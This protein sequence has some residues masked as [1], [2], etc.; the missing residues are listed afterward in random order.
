VSTKLEKL[1]TATAASIIRSESR[2]HIISILLIAALT[3]VIGVIS[4]PHLMDDVDGTQAQIARNMI[5]SGDWVT[6]RLDG[7]IFL[8]KAPLKFWMTVLLYRL[9]GVHDWVARIPNA[10]AALFLS[11]TVYFIGR[12][13]GSA[14]IGYY[15]G[16]VTA[17]SIG[18]FLFT[19]IVIP[20]IILTLAITLALWG[21]LRAVDDECPA[22]RYWAYVFFASMG[23]AML[24][25]GLI[26]VVFP[27]AIA[28]LYLAI[29]GQLL[30]LSA[31][32]RL[33]VGTGILMF[34]A[35][36]APWHILAI[37]RN[38]PYFDF[39]IHAGDHFGYKFRGFFWFYFVNDQI[40]RFINERW[41]RDYNTVPRLW[42]WLYHLI[43]FFPWSFALISTRA[44]QFTRETR[45]GRLQI[46]CLIWAGFI[47]FFF[48]FSTT[49]EYYS[50]P[51]YPALALLIGLA[52][53]REWKGS[54]VAFRVAG[55]IT[56]FACLALTAILIRVRNLPTPG[57][58]SDALSNNTDVYTL[59]LGHMADLTFAAF[60]YLRFPLAMAALAFLI[61]TWALWNPRQTRRYAGAAVMLVVFFQ[62][63]RLALVTFDPYLSSY[64]VAAAL[65]RMPK[66]TLV[67]NGAYYDFSSV[68]FYTQYNPL[69]LNGRYFNLEYGSYAPDAAPVFMDNQQFATLWNHSPSPVYVI[70]YPEKREALEK[71]IGAGHLHLVV[72]TGGKE[73]FSN[74][75]N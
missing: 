46:L 41:P 30:K 37:I 21:F 25:K 50:M 53:T 55:V 58:I 73:L 59:S 36:A 56:G 14:K 44:S 16:L 29:T 3:F 2:F 32:K 54:R 38:P 67:F 9:F 74:V 40:L 66:G 26:G 28:V 19:R 24:L 34:L 60:A 43:W 15:A 57:D 62:A 42:F 20:D 65:N 52:M 45:L 5:T 39:T 12:W 70:T 4:P 23:A 6:A 64:P 8:D 49:Q 47:L 31:W 7:V 27:A 13:A 18:L 72:R 69:L 10:A 71:L 1:P 51:M 35:V 22:R 48:T 61:G 33:H 17:T 63:A 11:L 68:P 75:S